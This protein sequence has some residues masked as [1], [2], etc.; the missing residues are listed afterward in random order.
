MRIRAYRDAMPIIE[1]QALPPAEGIDVGSALARVTT[2][3]ATYL[4]E[5]PRGTWRS[6][7]RWRP[8]HTRVYWG[9]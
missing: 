7:V 1:V 2:E 5:E 3:V 8:D 4:G 6:S 9:E